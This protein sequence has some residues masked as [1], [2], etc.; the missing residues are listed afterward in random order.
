MEAGVAG[1]W[2]L[3]V[4]IVVRDFVANACVPRLAIG[5]GG[6]AIIKSGRGDIDVV[7][8]EDVSR[9]SNTDCC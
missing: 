9:E 7:E 6:G 3:L 1:G 8:D 4:S 2:P 5:F